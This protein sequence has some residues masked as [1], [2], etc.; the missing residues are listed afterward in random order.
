MLSVPGGEKWVHDARRTQRRSRGDLGGGEKSQR[1]REGSFPEC[2]S[3]GDAG[4]G[5]GEG[6]VLLSL[7]RMRHTPVARNPRLL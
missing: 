4:V 1:S 7:P 5:K 6:P 2:L 3:E